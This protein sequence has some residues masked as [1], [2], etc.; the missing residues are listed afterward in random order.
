MKMEIYKQPRSSCSVT[1]ACTMKNCGAKLNQA[2]IFACSLSCPDTGDSAGLFRTVC[3]RWQC[4]LYT[5]SRI[6]GNDAHTLARCWD[7]KG[8]I[9]S[10]PVRLFRTERHKEWH[11]LCRRWWNC[12]GRGR[13]GWCWSSRICSPSRPSSSR[14]TDRSWCERSS[15]ISHGIWSCSILSWFL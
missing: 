14:G 7:R 8:S 15:C 9:W 3:R 10:R 4:P 12:W 2:I 6:S 5:R 11:W 13:S 1:D